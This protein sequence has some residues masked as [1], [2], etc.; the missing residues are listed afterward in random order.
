M[1]DDALTTAVSLIQV[2]V[3]VHGC[4]LQQRCMKIY[5]YQNICCFQSKCRL[6]GM[7]EYVKMQLKAMHICTPWATYFKY[8]PVLNPRHPPPKYPSNT[9]SQTA[10]ATP[11]WCWRDD[12]ESIYPNITA[13]E[14]LPHWRESQIIKCFK[15]QWIWHAFKIASPES[16]PLGRGA[17]GRESPFTHFAWLP[18]WKGFI[19]LVWF[20]P[21]SHIFMNAIMV[22]L[23][24][25]QP[26]PCTFY[27]YTRWLHLFF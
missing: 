10:A 13:Q 5:K 25:T 1:F 6:M 16:L 7:I 9:K 24:D 12:C 8:K 11:T 21:K 23:A 26:I 22:G 14:R 20:H 3:S 15:T 27:E 4:F 17:L 19:S 18:V 2:P